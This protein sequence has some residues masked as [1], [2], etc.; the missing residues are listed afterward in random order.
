MPL[1]FRSGLYAQSEAQ[2]ET[3]P[4]AEPAAQTASA[5]IPVEFELGYRFVKVSG[6]DDM[7]RTQIND[8]PGFLIRSLT[9]A[10]TAPAGCLLDYFRIDASDLGAGP[11]GSLKFS[12]GQVDRFR[13]DFSWRRTDLFSALPA[14]ANPQ[15]D[16]GVIPGQHTYDRTR[17]IY[18]ATLQILPGQTL[19]PILGFTRNIYR[20][21]GTTT[22]HLG[23]NDFH[24][25]EGM[26]AIDDEYRVGLAFNT[27]IVQGAVMQGYRQYRLRDTVS[28]IPG[29]GEGNVTFP[30]LGQPVTADGIER[31]TNSK[32]NSPVT[33]VWIAAHPLLETGSDRQLHP[34]RRE[35]VVRLHRDRR[36]ELRLLPDLPLLHGPRRHDRVIGAHELLAWI[37]ERGLHHRRPTS[38]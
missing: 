9:W 14:F 24:L 33:N 8:R 23:E 7:Y 17:D 36:R 37:G 11:A 6:N 34:R 30:I 31:T 22:F 18:D 21:P 3:K 28:L 12:A 4:A 2:P 27:K 1:S 35:R 38:T 16:D 13:I 32:T 26:S 15:L 5:S 10:S 25:N 20:G 19:T 29:A